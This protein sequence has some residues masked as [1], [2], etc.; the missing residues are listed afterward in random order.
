ME[1]TTRTRVVI[2]SLVLGLLVGVGLAH[3]VADGPEAKANITS[4]GAPPLVPH[5]D[6]TH[7]KCTDCHGADTHAPALGVP[8]TGH[9][10]R[11]VCRQCHVPMTAGELFRGNS[12][13][14]P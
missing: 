4:Y 3:L 13:E 7:E 6:Y 11:Q 2:I 8:T 1:R 9:A 12:Y 14:R 5:T 10:E